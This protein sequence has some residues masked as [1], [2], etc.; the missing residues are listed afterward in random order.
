MVSFK[1]L[2]GHEKK[3][4]FDMQNYN[5]FEFQPVMTT[6]SSSNKVLGRN[7][8]AK[9]SFTSNGDSSEFKTSSKESNMRLR[10]TKR[11]DKSM[12]KGCES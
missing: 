3:N 6:R 4:L 11:Y 12:R 1:L 10:K 8:N 2:Q 7:F 5:S 9:G